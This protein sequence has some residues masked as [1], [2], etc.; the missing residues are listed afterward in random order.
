MVAAPPAV[1]AF[2]AEVPRRA[3]GSAGGGPST[4]TETMCVP[5]RMVRPRVRFSSDSIRVGAAAVVEGGA[6][7]ALV[8]GLR[9]TRRNSSV[10]ARTRFM[11]LSKASIW[12]VRVRVSF[13]VIR[14]R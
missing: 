8:V 10:S 11:C 4:L 9:L 3:E 13:R 6:A 7:G 14:S 12:P 2:G 1:G 5:R